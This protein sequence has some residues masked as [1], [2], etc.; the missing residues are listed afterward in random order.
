MIGAYQVPNPEPGHLEPWH[1]DSRYPDSGYPDSGYADSEWIEKMTYM[2]QK[3]APVFDGGQVAL[4]LSCCESLYWRPNGWGPSGRKKRASGVAAQP[5]E[6]LR[7]R[8][9]S[10]TMGGCGVLGRQTVFHQPD[11]NAA[12]PNTGRLVG[13]VAWGD[14]RCVPQCHKVHT[15]DGNLMFGNQVAL[16]RF[17]DVPAN[18]G[19]LLRRHRG[20]GLRVQ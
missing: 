19:Y 13:V 15:V 10:H 5:Y 18:S 1:Q 3:T 20:R 12:G 14:D 4:V 17:G 7:S 16:D 11:V 8:R 6:L 9:G 2:R